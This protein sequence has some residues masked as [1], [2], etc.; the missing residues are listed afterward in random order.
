[1]RS[2]SKVISSSSM[3]HFGYMLSRNKTIKIALMDCGASGGISGDDMHFMESNEHFVD[4]IGLAGQNISHIQLSIAG[5]LI[6]T[7]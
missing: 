5:F 2:V 7:H 1:M 3:F 6:S 4:V